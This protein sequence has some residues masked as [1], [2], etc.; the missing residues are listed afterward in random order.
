VLDYIISVNCHYRFNT[1]PLAW[2]GLPDPDIP[3]TAA[4]I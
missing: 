2:L 4:E 1:L 3:T